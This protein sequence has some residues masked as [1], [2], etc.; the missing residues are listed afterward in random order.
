MLSIVPDHWSRQ[1]HSIE[2]LIPNTFGEVEVFL[3]SNLP[4]E[5]AA[6][7]IRRR[8][9]WEPYALRLRSCYFVFFRGSPVT[10]REQ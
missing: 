3:R 1:K 2:W 8:N 5:W 4:F 10:L 6:E 7:V 9:L